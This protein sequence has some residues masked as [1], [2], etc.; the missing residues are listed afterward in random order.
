MDNLVDMTENQQITEDQHFVPRFYMERFANSK[1]FLSVLDIK[2]AKIVK[3]RPYSGVCYKKFYYGQ[4][5]GVQ[6]EVS[7]QIENWF[8]GIE[9]D[10]ARSLPTIYDKIISYKQITDEERY[11]IST[12]SAMLWLRGDYMRLQVNKSSEDMMK[13]MM[14][15]DASRPGYKE[16][17]RKIMKEKGKDIT[18]EEIEKIQKSFIDKDYKL[19]FDNSSHLNLMTKLKEFSNMCFGKN[20]IVYLAKGQKRFITSDTPVAEWF[21]EIKNFAYGSSFL[22]RKHYI[23]LSPEMLIEMIYPKSG[24]KLK[25]KLATDQQVSDFNLMRAELSINYCYSQREDELQELIELRNKNMQD[26]NNALSSIIKTS[27]LL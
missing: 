4:K 3:P 12:L 26:Y 15:M 1:L 11:L 27:K 24:K 21:P 18:D 22:S 16:H 20:W 10:I 9:N 6:D 19:E 14:T 25:R 17:V 5:T 2:Q 13:W 23:A 8:T 7:Q